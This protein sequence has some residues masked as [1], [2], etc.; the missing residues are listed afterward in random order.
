MLR[1]V[2]PAVVGQDSAAPEDRLGQ[3]GLDGDDAQRRFVAPRGPDGDAS[4]RNAVARPDDHHRVIALSLD[5]PVPVR[6][7][8]PRVD[9]ARVGRHE[10]DH[11]ACDGP[12]G[13]RLQVPA[14]LGPENGRVPRVPRPGDH[15]FPDVLFHGISRS[16]APS[17]GR[18]DFFFASLSLACCPMQYDY[19]PGTPVSRGKRGGPAG[20]G[21]KKIDSGTAAV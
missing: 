14:D 12:C 10:T 19:P 1:R 7:D 4:E 11:G 6:R 13:H 16:S 17:G 3:P 5:E 8:R 20:A 2:G 18:P 15:G 21:Q 9:V